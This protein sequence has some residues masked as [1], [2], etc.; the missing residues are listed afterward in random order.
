[1][2]ATE[3]KIEREV[4]R[5]IDRLDRRLMG[6]DLTQVEYDREVVRVDKWARGEL[7]RATYRTELT[8]AGEQAVIPGCERNASPRTVQLNLFG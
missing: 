3:D 1:M 6:G 4:E 7:D 5:M 2:N 8:S